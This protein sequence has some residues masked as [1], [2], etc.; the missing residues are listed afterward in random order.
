MH[1]WSCRCPVGCALPDPGCAGD[2]CMP[3]WG[4]PGLEGQPP[5]WC[6]LPLQWLGR[7]CPKHQACSQARM[8]S[9][10]HLHQCLSYLLCSTIENCSWQGWPPIDDS[11]HSTL[12]LL[13]C[14]WEAVIS[15]DVKGWSWRYSWFLD[16]DTLKGRK[17]QLMARVVG[18]SL[19][20][21]PTGA[22]YDSISTIIMSLIEDSPQTRPT[23]IGMQ[24]KR[25]T[26]LA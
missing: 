25:L 10:R 13:Q 12:P 21:V 9:T 5:A 11:W 4:S 8:P 20:E 2:N 17:L 22:G 16:H 3:Q 14:T 24:F 7:R 15:V 26:K 18:F 6:A 19:C 23:S 1:Q